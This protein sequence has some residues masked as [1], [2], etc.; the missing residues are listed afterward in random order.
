MTETIPDIPWL[1]RFEEEPQE[2]PD[3]MEEI[4]YV[5]MLEELEFH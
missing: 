1:K 5:T 3:E 4:D 2:K